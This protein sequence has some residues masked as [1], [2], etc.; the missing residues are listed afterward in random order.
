MDQYPRSGHLKDYQA[1]IYVDPEVKP[2][3]QNPRRIPFTLR[4][5]VQAKVEEL[6][7]VD[8]IEKV[9]GPTPWVSPICVVPKSDGDIRLCV[10]IRR[11]NEAVAEKDTRFQQST[12]SF[13]I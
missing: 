12:K 8:V 9:D 5:K 4:G 11:A 13:K 1:K 7:N 3:A 2:V 6:L 10:D